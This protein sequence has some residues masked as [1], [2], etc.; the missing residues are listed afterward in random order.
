MTAWS[1]PYVFLDGLTTL[2][3]ISRN[4]IS[5]E[6]NPVAVSIYAAAGILG[7]FIVKLAAA[8]GA[9]LAVLWTDRSLAS[10]PDKRYIGYTLIALIGTTSFI[11]LNNLAGALGIELFATD[12]AKSPYI[13]I[14]PA[15]VA[16]FIGWLAVGMYN[17]IIGLGM[18]A[19][20]K[21]AFKIKGLSYRKDPTSTAG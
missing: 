19:R 9:G 15:V 6:L 3:L 5:G 20:R 18:L 7:L 21:W 10:Y 11:G 12:L 13:S 14:I 2:W 17:L 16:A 8:V 1:L 4:G